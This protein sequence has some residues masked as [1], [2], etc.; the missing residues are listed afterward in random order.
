MGLRFDHD[1][2]SERCGAEVK[3]FRPPTRMIAMESRY[4]M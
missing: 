4:I 3:P 2:V 1:Q